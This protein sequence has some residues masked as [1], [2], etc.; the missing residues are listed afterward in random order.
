M[1][2]LLLMALAAAPISDSLDRGISEELARERAEALSAVRYDLAFTVP[3]SRQQP[4]EGTLRLTVTL[5]APRRIVI[6]FSAPRERIRSVRVGDN[7]VVPQ[8]V[9][10]HLIIPAATTRSGDNRITIEFTA[11][12][13]ALNRND[14][15]LYTLFVPARA[16]LTFPCFDQPD[17]KARYTLSL[18]VPAGWE[19]VANGP[20]AGRET[21]GDRIR[22]RFGET[23]PLPTYLFGFVAGKFSI[24]RATRNGRE[25]RMFHRETDAAKVVRN[26]DALFDLHASALAWLE[27]Y[28]AIPYPF[29]KLDFILIPSF[30]F[31][32]ME[33]A[34]AILYN[35]AS[36]MLDESATQNQLL[37]RASTIAHET[38]HM[39]FGDLV[40]MR[41][42]N[43]VWMKEVFANFM[44]AKIV[45]PSFPTVN[46]ELRFLLSNYPDAY[47]VDRTA[48][49]NPIR[50]TLTNLNDA[51]Q[52]YGP[53]IYEKAPI[54]MR[55]L[56]MVVGERPFRDGL[57]EYLKKYAFGNA[58]WLD[59][60][61]I[62]DAKTPD[63]LAAWSRAW[64]EERGRPE[65][66]TRLRVTKNDTIQRLTLTMNDP[67]RRG[68]VWPQRMRVTLGY[69]DAQK[70]VAVYA[71]TR[72]TVIR[73]AAGM[74]RPLYLLPS[75]GGLGYGL[76]LLDEES[77]R[78][79]LANMAHVGDALT[80]GAAWVTLWD[81]VLEGRV[82][83]G[84]FIDGAIRAL[85]DESD[86]QNTQRVLAYVSRAFWRYLPRE[87]RA[88]RAPA[89]EAAL[90]AGI[91]RANNTSLKSAW[92]SAFRD[93]V[94]TADGVSWLERIW[95]RDEKI[96][97]LPFVETDEIDMAMELAVR[98]APGWQQILQTQLE[99]TQNPDR[100]ARF[101]FVMP[102]LS[103][104]PQVREQAFARFRQL[105][106]RRR[107][108]WVAE[109]L[110]YLNHPLRE[111][112]A[113]RFI[114]PGLELLAD[115]QRTGDIFF[116]S[117]W[118]ASL[119]WGH[120]TPGAAAIVRDFL[121]QEL[122]YPEQLRRTVLSS[123]DDLFRAAELSVR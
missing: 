28:T 73:E 83:P 2:T 68:L 94:L 55:Q 9:E 82:A 18:D 21:S 30:Q 65:F 48:G 11:G 95:R 115:I 99:R 40:T 81:N 93:D 59:L 62:L 26:R 44:A 25:M 90:R 13:E 86:E 79:L 42:F 80:R 3:V 123:A 33:H 102:A 89:L 122:A 75:G 118:T 67:L 121:A 71:N 7:A 106:N 58:T 17:L 107:E 54:V 100:K 63:N 15:F 51:G 91:E 88:A 45:N 85:P 108:P 47:S 38:A 31:G 27:D 66:T 92:F 97:G 105:E 61:R 23:R 70:D 77:V 72:E 109:S 113:E 37:N 78:Y 34:G 64:V 46:H 76:F 84:A 53:I 32:G 29:E 116:P 36:L 4:V 50:Q 1:L 49:A 10:D 35:S 41:W 22:V 39:W 60:I 112:D 96:P 104:D 56:E 14:D 43:D 52:L 69:A 19:T 111:A 20:E 12:D 110:A 74:P 120:R 16:H 101:A 6:D 24:E 114:R 117:N 5:A 57:R 98:E 8:F 103:A 87:E 119:L